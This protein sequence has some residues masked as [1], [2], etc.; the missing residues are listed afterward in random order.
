MLI[1]HDLVMQTCRFMG[2]SKRSLKN[3]APIHLEYKARLG[4]PIQ[5]RMDVSI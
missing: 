3:N 4:G 5:Y 2:D 1:N